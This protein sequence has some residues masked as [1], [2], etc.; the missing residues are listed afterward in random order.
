MKKQILLKQNLII[1]DDY[2]LNF[3]FDFSYPNEIYN[4]ILSCKHFNKLLIDKFNSIKSLITIHNYIRKITKSIRNVNLNE[5]KFFIDSYIRKKFYY[6]TFFLTMYPK[7]IIVKNIKNKMKELNENLKIKN[8][9]KLRLWYRYNSTE[10]NVICF[11]KN[12]KIL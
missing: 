2:L 9:F 3:I 5:D 4:L 1:F 11:K 7:K 6:H 10:L 8:K 12:F